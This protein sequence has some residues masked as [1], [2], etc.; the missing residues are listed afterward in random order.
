[1]SKAHSRRSL[2]A[3]LA[4]VALIAV[5]G[6]YAQHDL[7]DR[8]HEQGHCDL[9]SHL[10]GTAGSPSHAV[11]PGKPVLVVHRVPLAST[12]VLPTR[13]KAGTHLPRGPP[14]SLELI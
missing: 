4:A 12:I 9:C 14:H 10:S 7:G 3:L 13:R 1:M 11:V 6:L 8:T 5:S 2:V